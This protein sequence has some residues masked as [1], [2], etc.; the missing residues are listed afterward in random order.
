M[1]KTYVF[2]EGIYGWGEGYL[3]TELMDEFNKKV[4]T[5]VMYSN[6]VNYTPASNGSCAVIGNFKTSD[7][8]YF[9]A[10]EVVSSGVYNNPNFIN[11][12]VNLINEMDVEIQIK[13]LER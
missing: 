6:L 2:I 8:I 12:F 9:H 3:S 1:I 11:Y 7:Y 13:E 5:F 10:M 4:N